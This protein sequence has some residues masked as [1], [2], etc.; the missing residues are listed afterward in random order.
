MSGRWRGVVHLGGLALLTVLYT[1]LAV[2]LLPAP[3]RWRHGFVAHWNRQ[4]LR[5][6]RL[7]CGIRVRVEGREHLPPG[8]VVVLANHQSPFET[9]AVP[10][11]F[12]R[13]VTF[14]LKRELLRV[15]L[16][17]WGLRLMDPIAI[18]RSAPRAAL[19]A[20]LRQGAEVLGAGI[21]VVIFPEGTRVPPGQTRPYRAGGAALARRAGVP[22]VPLAHD[23]GRCWPASGLVRRPGTVCLRFGPPLDA[24]AEAEALTAQARAWIEAACAALSRADRP[25]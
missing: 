8:P 14:V 10:A 24:D 25:G 11:L 7:S 20:M 3:G 2:M 16:F 23:A 13:P 19:H 22:V 5:W 9:F 17:G 4:Q 18:D 6:L 1:P 21:S 15:P 12:G